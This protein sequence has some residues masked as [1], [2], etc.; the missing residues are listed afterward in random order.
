MYNRLSVG[1]LE[2][3]W[4][5]GG[6][7]M[8]DGGTMFGAVP[9]VLWEKKIPAVSANNILMLNAV[10]L[11]KSPDALILVDTGL[12][13]KL[14]EKQKN[15]Y[16]VTC[17]WNIPAELE[18]LGLDS[19]AIDYVVLTH[20]D[21]DHAGGVEMFDPDGRQRLSFA[22]ARYLVQKDEWYDVLHPNSRASH[23]YWDI[24][25]KNLVNSENLQIKEKYIAD[26]RDKNC[27]FTFYHDPDVLAC[28]FDKAG[29][30]I[31]KVT[32]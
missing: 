5:N 14:S 32:T 8:L 12:G 26:Y 30:I 7:F 28:R 1:N 20:C 25:F 15:I 24:N 10:L 9:K 22:N 31:E 19:T 18:K 6:E 11:I 21:F 2:I 29:R 17:D 23:S 4:L 13:N 3:Y 16:E 27:W